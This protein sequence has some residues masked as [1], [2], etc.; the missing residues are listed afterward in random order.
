MSTAVRSTLPADA[1]IGILGT[2][3]IGLVVLL[4]AVNAGVR[5][6][7][8]TDKIGAR[9][10]AAGEL[11]ALWTGNPDGTDIVEK[12]SDLEPLGLDVVFDCCGKQEA[13]EILKELTAK[14]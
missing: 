5:R 7:Y 2:G 14:E 12:I 3:P 9:L 10:Q 4:A 13:L 11:G 8:A 1:A 6:I